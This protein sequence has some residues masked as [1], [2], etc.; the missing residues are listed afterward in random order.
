MNRLLRQGAT[1]VHA[2][3]VLGLYLLAQACSPYQLRHEGQWESTDQVWM[4]EASQ[5]K[6]RTAQSRVFDTTDRRRTLAAVIATLQDIS[7]RVDVV[8]EELGIISGKKILNI[9]G[10]V[11][12]PLFYNLYDDDSLLFLTRTYRTWGPFYHRSD[13]VRITVTVRPRGEQQL[14]VRAST[15]FYLQ[16][17]EDPEPYQRFFQSLEQALFL[18]AKLVQ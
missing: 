1:G 14:V 18:E 15:Q 5:V 13:L 10:P 7:F 6:L 17:I 4:S 11:I 12:H 8:D 2:G 16:A 3:W 9:E